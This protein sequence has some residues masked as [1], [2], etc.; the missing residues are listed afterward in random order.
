MPEKHYV[1]IKAGIWKGDKLFLQKDKRKVGIVYDLPGGRIEPGE[2]I[3]EGL[4][5]EVMEEMGVNLSWVSD[6]P[7]KLWSVIGGKDGVVALLYEAELE[8]EDF[9]FGKLIL[10][11]PFSYVASALLSST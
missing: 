9:V 4:R 7:V 6:M 3:K 1:T 8:S 11:M 10:K 2:D 5:R